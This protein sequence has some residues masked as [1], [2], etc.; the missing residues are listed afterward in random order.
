V[1]SLGALDDM[2]IS[3]DSEG[4]DSIPVA[5]SARTRYWT[6][7]PGAIPARLSKRQQVL[8]AGSGNHDPAPGLLP[9]KLAR[10]IVYRMP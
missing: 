8:G 7:L 4:W 2:A 10:S 1:L 5:P 9:V 6:R 3:F